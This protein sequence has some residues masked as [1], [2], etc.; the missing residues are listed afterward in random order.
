ML[1][2]VPMSL[3]PSQTWMSFRATPLA[4]HNLINLLL[5]G[6]DHL[7]SVRT[8]YSN[9]RQKS[10]PKFLILGKKSAVFLQNFKNY[11]ILLTEFI[12]FV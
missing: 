7:P 11:V 1:L 5:F 6:A 12:R 9:R 2:V 10:I 4:Y 8:T 3:W